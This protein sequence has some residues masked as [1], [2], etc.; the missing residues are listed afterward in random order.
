MWRLPDHLRDLAQEQP[1]TVA[2][3]LRRYL[4]QTTTQVVEMRSSLQG[5][6]VAD[7]CK[8]AACVKASSLE[9]GAERMAQF[10]HSIEQRNLPNVLQVLVSSGFPDSAPKPA[11][12]L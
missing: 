2:R 5:K 6:N 7:A 4:D 1:E 10:C 3:V 9:V 11:R 12:P 8:I